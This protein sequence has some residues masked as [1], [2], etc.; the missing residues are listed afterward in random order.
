V[1]R[2]AWRVGVA[3]A[4]MGLVLLPMTALHGKLV[5]VSVVV[6]AAVYCVALMAVRVFDADEISIARRALRGQT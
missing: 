5:A 1:W 6:G 4:V 3:G 2:L